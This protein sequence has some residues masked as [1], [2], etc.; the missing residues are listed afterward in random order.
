[1][2]N[3]CFP[4]GSLEFEYMTGRWSYNTSY[5]QSPLIT[6][7]GTYTGMTLD[8]ESGFLQTLPYKPSLLADFALY[9][10]TLKNHSHEYNYM[11][12]P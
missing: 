7:E 5:I 4:S 8:T 11:L 9:P 2:L 3:M 12:S 6:R 1:M 10:F